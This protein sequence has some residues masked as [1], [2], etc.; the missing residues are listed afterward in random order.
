MQFLLYVFGEKLYNLCILYA[1][2]VPQG[3]T[4]YPESKNSSLLEEFD[5]VFAK[6]YTE[7][8]SYVQRST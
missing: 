6:G 7:G 3:F 2:R 5:T 8:I 1:A 4:L